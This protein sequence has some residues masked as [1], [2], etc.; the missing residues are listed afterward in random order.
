[1]SSR[2]SGPW[3]LH[4]GLRG[5]GRPELPYMVRRRIIAPRFLVRIK[6]S[7]HYSRVVILHRQAIGHPGHRHTTTTK[8]QSWMLAPGQAAGGP[9]PT[10]PWRPDHGG[11]RPPVGP[12]DLTLA[13][14]FRCTFPTQNNPR[15]VTA[16]RPSGSGP[17]DI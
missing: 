11:A 8:W 14:K 5:R 2:R 13:A 17:Q 9:S 3:V 10:A 15:S 12:P 6:E 4:A 16:V 7:C 1:M